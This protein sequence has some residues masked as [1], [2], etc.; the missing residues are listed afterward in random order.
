MEVKT[1][2]ND[3][4]SVSASVHEP[5]QME[6]TLHNSLVEMDNILSSAADLSNFFFDMVF[7][8]WSETHC[9]RVSNETVL[10]PRGS[11]IC[12]RRMRILHIA[13]NEHGLCHRQYQ[14]EYRQISQERTRCH[15]AL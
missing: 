14:L 15:S 12:S 10:D 9:A 11:S 8:M 13:M 7:M 5:H 6:L 2:L 4:P 3:T 1:G